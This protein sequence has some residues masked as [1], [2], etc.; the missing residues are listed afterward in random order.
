MVKQNIE[1]YM[2]DNEISKADGQSIC[3]LLD[4]LISAADKCMAKKHKIENTMVI[5]AVYLL[6]LMIACFGVFGLISSGLYLEALLT[7]PILLFLFYAST[8]Q[9]LTFWRSRKDLSFDRRELVHDMGEVS[10]L[11]QSFIKLPELDQMKLM[12]IGIKWA[13]L[14]SLV[15][16]A[17]YKNGSRLK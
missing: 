1:Q 7:S 8:L 6:L 4:T 3:S 16:L 17:T 9:A 11:V 2:K 5:T 14:Q 15:R 10:V 13:Y 12:T